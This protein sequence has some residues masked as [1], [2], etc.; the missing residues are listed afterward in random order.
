MSHVDC[1]AISLADAARMDGKFLLQIA[2]GNTREIYKN[3]KYEFLI[4]QNVDHKTKLPFFDLDWLIVY[5]L[6]YSFLNTYV[7]SS[8]IGCYDERTPTIHLPN[9]FLAAIPQ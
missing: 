4:V 7:C 2:E 9:V 5:Y 8:L 1:H 3:R 6:L